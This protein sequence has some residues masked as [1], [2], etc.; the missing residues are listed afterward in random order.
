M[1]SRPMVVI[2]DATAQARRRSVLATDFEALYE[3]Y[4]HRV[5]M[6]CLRVVRNADDAEDLRQE[7][8]LV[9]FRKIDMYRGQSAFSTWLYRLATNVALMRVRRKVLPQTSVDEILETHEGAINP[10]LELKDSVRAQTSL[11][12]RVDLQRIYDQ[13]PSGYR[14]ALLLHDSEEYT[15]LEI[16][17]LTGWTTGTSK[18]QLYKARQ[19]IRLLFEGGQGKAIRTRRLVRPANDNQIQG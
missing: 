7:V 8:F 9:L 18:S 12:T 4:Q 15:H 17:E 3:L 14:K 10:R 16:S 6:W 2:D 13:M 19:R 5:F 11:A 1:R